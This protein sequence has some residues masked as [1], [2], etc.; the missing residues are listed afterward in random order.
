MVDRE[1]GL[2]HTGDVTVTDGDVSF[3]AEYAIEQQL[4]GL[5]SHKPGRCRA[6]NVRKLE[7]ARVE[8]TGNALDCRKGGDTVVAWTVIYA[9]TDGRSFRP[10]L[11]RVGDEILLFD[12]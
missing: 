8:V 6:T 12:P 11:V 7:S 10:S 4:C 3:Q 9:V 5:F 1:L 2:E